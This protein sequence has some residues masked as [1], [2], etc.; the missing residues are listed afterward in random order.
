MFM[1]KYKQKCKQTSVLLRLSR[2]YYLCLAVQSTLSYPDCG[3][4]IVDQYLDN[5]SLLT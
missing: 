1:F 4:T 3:V 5:F 2:K